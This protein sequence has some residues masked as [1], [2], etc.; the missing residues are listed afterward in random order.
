MI[1]FFTWMH[2]FAPVFTHRTGNTNTI[3]VQLVTILTLWSTLISC[4]TLLCSCGQSNTTHVAEK[5]AFVILIFA[6]TTRDTL[7]LNK[8]IIYN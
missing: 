6:I 5:L 2:S 1:I 4:Q 7:I 8:T 3:K